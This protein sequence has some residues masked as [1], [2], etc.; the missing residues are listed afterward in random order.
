MRFLRSP[1]HRRILPTVPCLRQCVLAS[2]ILF[3]AVIGAAAHDLERTQVNLT[4]AN[5]GSFL[6]E[7]SN[8]PAWLLLRL[9][10]FAGGAVPPGLSVEARDARLRQLADVFVDRVVLFVDGREIRP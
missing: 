2:A 7:I 9:E 10:S 6:L 3:V 5:D 1:S 4:F 8:A